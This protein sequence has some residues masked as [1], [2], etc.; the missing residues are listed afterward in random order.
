MRPL[1]VAVYLSRLSADP[2][3]FASRVLVV[4]LT[5]FATPVGPPRLSISF[6][7][8]VR[9]SLAM[10]TSLGCPLDP[11]KL[12]G[13]VGLDQDQLGLPIEIEQLPPT[14]PA[15]VHQGAAVPTISSPP[16]T[17]ASD[18]HPTG[19]CVASRPR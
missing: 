14:G 18:R 4:R 17:S 9:L 1:A 7:L 13:P 12:A 15:S 3:C 2:W 5:W 19:L 6:S 10:V 8:Y 16:T 11:S